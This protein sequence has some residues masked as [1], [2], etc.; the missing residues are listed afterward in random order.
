MLKSNQVSP[1]LS[2]SLQSSAVMD[3]TEPPKQRQVAIN[4]AAANAAHKFLHNCISTAKY[5]VFTFLP[6]FLKEQF[7]KYANDFFLFTVIIQV[8]LP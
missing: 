3:S 2:T 1:T 7:S 8:P 5:N 6:K 4:D